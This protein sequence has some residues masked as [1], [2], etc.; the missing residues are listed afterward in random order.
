Y[1]V[2]QIKAYRGMLFFT[3][4]GVSVAGHFGA[5]LTHGDEYLTSVLP[6]GGTDTHNA[7]TFD[8]TSYEADSG[9]LSEDQQIKLLGEVRAIMAHSCYSCHSEEKVRGDLRLDSREAVFAGGESGPII[10]PG[11]ASESEF[12]RRI[13]LP[14]G[15]DDVMPSKGKLLTEKEIA[16][17][18]L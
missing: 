14:K 9:G 12:V 7:A 11:S 15:H 13:S 18:S 1:K 8:F 16:L 6:W 17:I 10:V 3:A 4:V 2:S 5:S